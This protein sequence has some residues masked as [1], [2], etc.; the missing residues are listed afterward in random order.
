M[1]DYQALTQSMIS[2][3]KEGRGRSDEQPVPY[4]YLLAFIACLNSTNLG[5]DIG[6]Q[7]H[8]RHCIEFLHKSASGSV[9]GA[10]VL[11]RDQ[12]NWTRLQ[13]EWFVASANFVAVGGAMI[14]PILCDK[15]GR[16]K[17][18]T[19]S[20][21]VF[22]SGLLLVVMSPS[23]MEKPYVLMMI[24]RVFTGLGIGLGLAIDPLYIAGKS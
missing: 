21:V 13:T 24:G 1:L 12:L 6:I 20:C 22:V 7:L 10:S 18:F 9:G 3:N 14:A 11:M 16:R 23:F 17:T 8:R 19:I 15:L 4:V 2:I 5:Y